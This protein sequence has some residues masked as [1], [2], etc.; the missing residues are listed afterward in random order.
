M[1]IYTLRSLLAGLILVIVTFALYAQVSSHGYILFDDDKYIINNPLVN[2]GLSL[3]ALYKVFTQT[4]LSNWHPLTTATQM[5][6]VELFGMDLGKHHL[7]NVFLHTINALLI[8]SFLKA[9]S[10]Q[11][12]ASWLVAMLFA[13]HP[14]HV[15]SVAWLSERKDVLSTMFFMLT[16]WFYYVYTQSRSKTGFLLSVISLGMGLLSK[17]MLVTT[18]FVLLLLD[19]WPLKRISFQELKRPAVSR[20]IIEKWPYFILV[21]VSAIVTYAIQSQS[22]AMSSGGAISLAGKFE[23]AL[24]SYVRYLWIAIYPAELT[25]FYP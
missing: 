20:L 13:I 23:N 9:V 2:Q 18:P 16:L 8:F 25:I 14:A 17:P 3:E 7:V 12:W 5:L 1:Q 11:L 22:G 24:V 10:G 19:I 15:E 21:F 4:H 6:D